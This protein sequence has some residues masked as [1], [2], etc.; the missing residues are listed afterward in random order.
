MAYSITTLVAALGP[1]ILI[2]A[3]P[4]CGCKV[5][6]GR[7]GYARDNTSWMIGRL[8]RDMDHWAGE[9][10]RVRMQ[11]NRDDRWARMRAKDAAAAKPPTRAGLVVLVYAP[12]KTVEAGVLRRDWLYWSCVVTM[13]LQ[14][15]LA[16]VPIGVYGDWGILLLT[17]A[18]TFLA[19]ATGSLPQW[20]KEKWACRRASDSPFILTEGNGR[21]L[22][23]GDLFTGQTGKEQDANNNNYT[24]LSLLVTATG[25]Q[26]HTW[27]L[28]GVYGDASV[29]ETLFQVMEAY[30]GI[31]RVLRDDDFFPGRLRDDEV[32]RW[33]ALEGKEEEKGK[34]RGAAEGRSQSVSMD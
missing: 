34:G 30:A 32:A 28:V 2:P 23:L 21:G 3:N 12:S 7:S 10:T 6:S 22:N 1:N 8:A 25:V 11:Q 24:W 31:G 18:G 13:V 15:G 17:V 20:K 14:L 5:I 33:E 4:D 26:E 19:V 16:A 9:A 29:M 27:F